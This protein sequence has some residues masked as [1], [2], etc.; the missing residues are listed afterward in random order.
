MAIKVVRIK[1]EYFLKCDIDTFVEE[2]R[3]I[4]ERWPEIIDTPEFIECMQA[5]DQEVIEWHE[6]QNADVY[7]IQ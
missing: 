7:T 4:L 6:E 5:R 2:L 1:P 3:K